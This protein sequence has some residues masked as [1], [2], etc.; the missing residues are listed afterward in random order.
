MLHR[1]PKDMKMAQ[2][3]NCDAQILNRHSP[4]SMEKYHV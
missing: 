1:P 3:E 4:L 2:A